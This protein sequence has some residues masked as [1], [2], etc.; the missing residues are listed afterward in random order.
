MVAT[1]PTPVLGAELDIG[2]NLL[3]LELYSHETRLWEFWCR[4]AGLVWP[5]RCERHV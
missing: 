5:V 2:F 4:G 1:K 3:I